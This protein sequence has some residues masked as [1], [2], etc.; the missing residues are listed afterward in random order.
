MEE[1][2]DWVVVARFGRVHGIK[3]FIK[4]HTYTEF[5]EDFL[6]Y[7]PLYAQIN[8]SWQQLKLL[9]IQ[10]TDRFIMARVQ[11]FDTR[12]HVAQLTHT[13]IAIKKS[14]LPHL[15]VGEYYWHDL[16]GKKV[17]NHQGDSL[18]VVQEI[19]A[20]GSNDVLVVEGE[21]RHL[22]PYLPSLFVR[23]VNT[24]ENTILVDW[25]KDF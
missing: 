13:T 14:Q 24:A 23:E 22:I 18:G 7:N 8:S 6:N 2:V 25:D 20:T 19:L 10:V 5:R 17:I 1:A 3:G 15:P 9:D 21:K 12:E 4:I 11:G 16:I